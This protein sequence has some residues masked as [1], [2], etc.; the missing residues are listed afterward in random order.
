MNS[1][2]NFVV[3]KSEFSHQINGSDM[4]NRMDL[5]K[6]SKITFVSNPNKTCRIRKLN[7]YEYIDKD[8]GEIKKYKLDNPTSKSDVN[9]K[10][11]RYEEIVIFNFTGGASQ[12]I[13]TAIRFT[14]ILE[15]RCSICN[16]K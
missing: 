4:V 15:T 16:A 14:T 3:S 7:K 9:R 13:Y 5:G 11:K 1:E 12:I 10:L 6:Y 8:T 2:N